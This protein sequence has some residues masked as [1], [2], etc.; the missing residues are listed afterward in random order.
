MKFRYHTIGA[1]LILAFATS[2]VLLAIVSMVAWITWNT[3]D[4]QV[5]SLL[6]TSVPKYNASYQLESRS[7]QIRALI[8]YLPEI[9]NTVVLDDHVQSLHLELNGIEETLKNLRDNPQAHTL[10]SGYRSLANQI[11]LYEELVRRHIDKMRA[12]ARI[13]EQI[14]WIHQDIRSEL[15][16]LRQE[17]EWQVE[18]ESNTYAQAKLLATL[19]LIQN[20]TDLE[21][22]LYSLLQEVTMFSHVSQVDNGMKVIQFRLDDLKEMSAPLYQIP[23][24]ISYQ[25]LIGELDSLLDLNGGF[26]LALSK[27]VS[28]R[29]S[30]REQQE[31]I[32]QQLNRLHQNVAYLASN[33]NSDFIAVKSDTADVISYGNQILIACFSLSILTSV[34]LTYY[35]IHR[36]IVSRL[37]ALST[38]LDAMTHK[39][40]DFP[41]P[42]EGKDEI[43]GISRKLKEFYFAMLEMEQTNAL[44]L[45]NNTHS[46]LVTCDMTGRIESVNMSA[47]QLFE[48]PNKIPESHL[49]NWIPKEKQ[50][51]LKE[52]FAPQ[53][54]LLTAGEANVVL[55]LGSENAPYYLRFYLSVFQQGR[56]EK[57][58]VT[59]VDITEQAHANHLLEQR[60][61]E[62]TKDLVAAN[63][64]LQVEIEER[65]KAEFHLKET[66]SELIQA[67]KMAVVGQTMSSLAHELNQPL[68]AI[69]TYLF[70]AQMALKQQQYPLTNES[71]SRISV[72]AERMGKII[73]SLRHFAK[74]QPQDVALSS[75]SLREALDQALVL[76]GTQAKKLEAAIEL[77]VKEEMYVFADNV[78]LEQVLVNLLVNSLEAISEVDTRTINI[79][80]EPYKTGE[81]MLFISDSGKGFD[82]N[83]IHQIFTPFTTTKEVGLG[84][85]LNICRSILN[86]F[87]AKI[88]LAS[89]LSR[90]ALVVLELPNDPQ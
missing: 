59:V 12:S 48:L 37:T 19:R 63:Q 55:S 16:P 5:E 24:A 27:L 90:G 86:R 9:D 56:A 78:G 34:F 72:M 69:S 1:K 21:L 85:G 30:L 33:A 14:Q 47:K 10:L 66:Q 4:R 71:L 53:S 81:T 31:K 11:S 36:R 28:S 29:H 46:S 41:F 25:Q 18:R 44:N 52:L 38:T 83:V 64:D 54:R 50:S 42:V 79:S 43:A 65:V 23:S 76:V 67:A 32:S 68:T 75:I 88:Y 40:H 62:K 80:C 82:G 6:T 84:L 15:K 17:I 73:N 7:S 61:A 8:N 60:V 58:M 87:N 2:T 20:V 49:W 45:I 77:D 51:A 57:V 89:T 74:K 22:A 13:N 35:F 26:H 70:S 39:K 3:L